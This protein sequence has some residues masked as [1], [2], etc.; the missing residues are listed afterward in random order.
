VLS[1]K[2]ASLRATAEYGRMGSFQIGQKWSERNLAIAREVAREAGATPSPV[3]LA[4]LWTWN[5]SDA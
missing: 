5:F 2:Y 3:A 4:W 1:G